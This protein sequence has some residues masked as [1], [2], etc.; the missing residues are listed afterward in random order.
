MNKRH[1]RRLGSDRRPTLRTAIALLLTAMI[2]TTGGPELTAT[3]LYLLTDGITTAVTDGTE[4]VDAERIVLPGAT[5]DGSDVTLEGGR[6]VTIRQNGTEQ[7]ATSRAGETV[8]WLLRR[9]DVTV[10]PLEMVLVDLSGDDI[11]LEIASDFT[12]Y[13]TV[14][15][16]GTHE[17]VYVTDYTIPKGETVVTQQGQDGF[18]EETY[19]VIYADGK[20]VSRQAVAVSDGTV[21]DEIVSTGTLVKAA[22]KGDTIASV[23]EYEDGS[24]YLL[25]K[26]GDSLHFTGSMQVSCTAYNSAEP[27]VGT[28]TATGTR[29]H[30]GVVAVDRRV[31]PLGTQMFITTLDGSY[32]YGMGSAEDTGVFGKSVDLYMDSVREMNQ[33][34]RRPSIVYF[35]DD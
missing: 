35:L 6:K 15:V 7:Y 33:F 26:S 16:A 14:P 21:V 12:Y 34:G 28:I 2:L 11:V 23:V 18:R 1:Q 9:S 22:Q 29:V 25:L 32:T 8:S 27:L 19:E 4:R 30:V 20:L 13:E 31:I 3:A 10:G 5:A 17:T 24:G